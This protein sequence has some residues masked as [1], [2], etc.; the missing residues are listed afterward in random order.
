V[1][2]LDWEQMVSR[3][4]RKGARAKGAKANITI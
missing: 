4:C 2:E 3:K 1:H